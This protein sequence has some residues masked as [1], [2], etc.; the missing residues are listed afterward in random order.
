MHIDFAVNENC[1]NLN[2]SYGEICVKCNCCGRFDESTK[3]KCQL[4]TL[5]GR[6]KEEQKFDDW[7]EGVEE[8]QRSNVNA[9]IEYLETKIREIEEKLRSEV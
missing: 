4:E 6:L 9:N 8:L 5:K 7:S 1:E 2:G 3:Y